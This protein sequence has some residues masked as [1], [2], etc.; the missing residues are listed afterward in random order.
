ME[1]KYKFPQSRIVRAHVT[2]SRTRRTVADVAAEWHASC[3]P[4]NNS[5]VCNG[6]DYPLNNPTMSNSRWI[7]EGEHINATWLH[8]RPVMCFDRNRRMFMWFRSFIGTYY[9]EKMKVWNGFS[10][11]RRLIVDG[12]INPQFEDDNVINNGIGFGLTANQEL[13]IVAF[14]GWDFHH[15]GYSPQGK[16]KTELANLMLEMGVVHGGDGGYGGGLVWAWDGQVIN[17][18]Y[19]D[20]DPMHRNINHLCLE[21]LPVDDP[22]PTPPEPPSTG[23]IITVT[24][25]SGAIVPIHEDINEASQ[26]VGQ[27]EIDEQIKVY[28]HAIPDNDKQIYGEKWFRFEDKS[29]YVQ[30]TE[31]DRPPD[32]VVTGI[33][34]VYKDGSSDLTKF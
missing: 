1:S 32:R 9:P 10:L 29:G 3:Q 23:E 13:V 18:W 30:A 20:G 4:G 24:N 19:N 7:S 8:W 28:G 5:F 12:A 11:T 2:G 27:V 25:N 6:D 22:G 21:L 15:E 33:L 16:T 26:V 34:Y 14:D 31:F 17:D